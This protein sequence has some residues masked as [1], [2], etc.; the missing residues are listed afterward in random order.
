MVGRQKGRNSV[1]VQ[2]GVHEAA[3]QSEIGDVG[4]PV[5]LPQEVEASSPAGPH[6]IE[7]TDLAA[8]LAVAD[9]VQH[10]PARH[11]AT[12]LLETVSTN[13]IQLHPAESTDPMPTASE[14][15]VE[16]GSE[17]TV[18]KEPASIPDAAST[19]PEPSHNES[20]LVEEEQTDR[21]PGSAAPAEPAP[22]LAFD[23]GISPYQPQQTRA[24]T[25]SQDAV[26]AGARSREGRASSQAE[27]LGS[28]FALARTAVEANV[29]VWS[30]L[31]KEGEAALAHVR[32]LSSA[33]SPADIMD[34]QAREMNR[35]LGATQ[36]LG[37]ELADAAGKLMSNTDA[38]AK[39][40]P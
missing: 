1:P 40:K 24:D 28:P 8:V 19:S 7:G 35:A 10:E 36:S 23:E 30:Y 4:L 2:Q 29:A 26:D 22:A 3:N 17:K 9:A 11:L 31:R 12:E 38:S 34:L 15:H 14:D 16:N 27:A 39:K 37:R 32:A 21:A 5:E 33:R 25:S 20:A 13:A 6:A 18:S